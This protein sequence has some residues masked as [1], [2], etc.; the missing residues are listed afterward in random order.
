[1]AIF[2]LTY[3]IILKNKKQ[4]SVEEVTYDACTDKRNQRII[5]MQTKKKL[6]FSFDCCRF[7]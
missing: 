1:M 4:I 7:S 6:N 5:S 2:P 3:K